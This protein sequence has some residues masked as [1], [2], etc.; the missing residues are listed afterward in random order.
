MV[1]LQLNRAARED[2]KCGFSILFYLTFRLLRKHRNDQLHQVSL[3]TY[4]TFSLPFQTSLFFWDV[5]AGTWALVEVL[6]GFR[7]L[8]KPGDAAG[9]I[10]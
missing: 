2:K 7:H 5:G 1:S 10:L 8:Q 9:Q 4:T 3:G 6:I